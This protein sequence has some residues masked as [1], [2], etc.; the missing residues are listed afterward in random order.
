[1][2][3]FKGNQDKIVFHYK[4]INGSYFTWSQ[5]SF[6]VYHYFCFRQDIAMRV[7]LDGGWVVLHMKPS[8]YGW[9]LYSSLARLSFQVE[10]LND[11]LSSQVNHS[12]KFVCLGWLSED[13]QRKETKKPRSSSLVMI[14]MLTCRGGFR[15]KWDIWLLRRFPWWLIWEFHPEGPQR[16]NTTQDVAVSSSGFGWVTDRHHESRKQ[17]ENN[18]WLIDRWSSVW[19]TDWRLPPGP[20]CKQIKRRS[21]AT[22]AVGSLQQGSRVLELNVTLSLWFTRRQRD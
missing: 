13:A 20:V 6:K 18:S 8:E 2:T 14:I 15:F 17:I 19:V 7:C 10:S 5:P 11:A 22:L 3:F 21:S 4:T 9:R 1:M 16:N 12:L